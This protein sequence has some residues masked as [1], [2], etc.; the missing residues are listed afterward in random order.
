MAA[1]TG[2]GAA[3]L[4]I[5]P[6]KVGNAARKVGDISWKVCQQVIDLVD[7]YGEDTSQKIATATVSLARGF[8]SNLVQNVVNVDKTPANIALEYEI[9]EIESNLEYVLQESEAAMKK[10]ESQQANTQ[11]SNAATEMAMRNMLAAR[12]ELEKRSKA[13]AKQDATI[14]G[15]A[16]LAESRAKMEAMAK[17]LLEER[18]EEEKRI[19]AQRKVIEQKVMAE[20]EARLAIEASAVEEARLAMEATAIEEARLEMEARTIEEARLEM[21]A[22]VMEETRLVMEATA[23]EEA[24]LAMEARIMEEARL[25]ME[26]RTIEEA[27]LAMEARTMEETRLVMEARI[28][29]EARLAMEAR[30]IE[31][32]RLVM[33]A[34]VMEETRLVMEAR[35]IEETRLVMEVR[36]IEE[37]RRAAETV[38]QDRL[39]EENRRLEIE[40]AKLAERTELERFAEK[41]RLEREKEEGESFLDDNDWEASIKLATQNIEGKIAGFDN[42]Q[43]DKNEK[44]DWNKAS[45][46]AKDLAGDDDNDDEAMSVEALAAQAKA[47]RAAVKMFEAER[48]AASAERK[49]QKEEW[50]QNMV[51]S[52]IPGLAEDLRTIASA[53]N[54]VTSDDMET[55][56]NESEMAA[57]STAVEKGKVTQGPSAEDENDDDFESDDDFEAFDPE[58]LDLEALGAAARAAVDAMD[59]AFKIDL[60]E[61]FE[62]FDMEAIG[63]AARAAVVKASSMV[64]DDEEFAEYEEFDDL[65]AEAVGAATRAAVERLREEDIIEEFDI[66]ALGLAARQAVD[67][68]DARNEAPLKKWSLMKVADLK[69]ELLS[70]GLKATGKKAELVASLEEAD[71]ADV[72]TEIEFGAF[73]VDGAFTIDDIYFDADEPSEAELIQLE[74]NPIVYED[75]DEDSMAETD[76]DFNVDSMTVSQLKVE[77]KSRGL[78]IVGRKA[79]LVERLK[80]NM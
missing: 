13:K 10:A 75:G 76:V 25:A 46:L 33:E 19:V 1:G 38:E 17:S 2:L 53:V 71:N 52:N 18:L 61:D 49:K 80:G 15:E 59:D 39:L 65:N 60:D 66:N 56:F 23:I 12:F 44:V 7:T 31:E 22:R 78:A 72:V 70:R 35:A 47:A 36:E 37:A 69:V 27:R 8:I 6:G 64:Q 48:M 63:A 79:E 40:R 32:A 55:I 45:R 73:G 16:R 77:L 21:E 74:K 20:E 62:E 29:E 42:F 4:C 28:M 26:A 41:A 24:R 54:L 30:T 68:F 11:Q 58:E 5:T 14:L 57:L 50:A 9:A 3:Y 43:L 51:T 67:M 34:R